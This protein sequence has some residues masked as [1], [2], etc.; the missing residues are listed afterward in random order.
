MLTGGII[1]QMEYLS[2][3]VVGCAADVAIDA[4]NAGDLNL[5]FLRSGLGQYSPGSAY[6]K[7]ALVSSGI[8]PAF[9]AAYDGDEQAQRGLNEFVRLVAVRVAPGR[10]EEPEPG[11]PFWR[12]RESARADGFDLRAECSDTNEK[13]INVRLLPLEEPEVPLSE[14]VTALEADF[15]A[16]GMTVALSHYRQAVDNFV[17]ANYEAANGQLR[18][19]F[20][21]VV[22]HFATQLGFSTPQQGAGGQA[23]AYLRD[24][25]HLLP[26]DGGD[27]IRGLWWIVQTNGP[28]PGTTTAGEVHFRMLTMTGAARY[29]IDQFG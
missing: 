20:E 18:S 24:N 10:S 7:S 3:V 22:I 21:A 17:D 29:L 4:F 28:H 8:V 14:E 27:F 11:T 13:L 2:S 1:C 6:G 19:M 15:N 5:L 12:L 26:R 25:G 16:R 23:I 9:R